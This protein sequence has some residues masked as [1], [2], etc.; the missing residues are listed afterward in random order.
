M[1]TWLNMFGAVEG[2]AYQCCT[3]LMSGHM[4]WSVANG[5]LQ[6]ELCLGKSHWKVL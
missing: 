4:G 1:L 2:A 6:K 5:Y 3:V